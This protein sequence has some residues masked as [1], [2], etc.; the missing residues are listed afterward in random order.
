MAIEVRIA[1]LVYAVLCAAVAGRMAVKRGRSKK[2][3]M[4]AG[5][6]FG[7][8]ALAVLALLPNPR[9]ANA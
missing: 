6:L 2:G 9:N 8:L 7:V 1:L 4:I 5:A 3:W